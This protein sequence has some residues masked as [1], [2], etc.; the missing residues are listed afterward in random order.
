[1]ADDRDKSD[2]TGK[3]KLILYG[4]GEDSHKSAGWCGGNLSLVRRGDPFM[5]ATW[6]LLRS[7]H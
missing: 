7:H 2:K 6:F 5:P 1:M 4:E 3:E